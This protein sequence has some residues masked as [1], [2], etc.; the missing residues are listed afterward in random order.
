M[1]KNFLDFS[2]PNLDVSLKFNLDKLISRND[3]TDY[4]HSALLDK[5][6]IN[7]FFLDWS[8]GARSFDYNIAKDRVYD[9][10]KVLS[11]FILYLHEKYDLDLKKVTCIGFSLGGKF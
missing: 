1:L 10:A 8:K 5:D 7:L 9:V 2:L 4:F 6:D 3:Y 11:D